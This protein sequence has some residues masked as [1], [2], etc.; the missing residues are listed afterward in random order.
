VLIRINIKVRNQGLTLSIATS[1]F[2]HADEEHV[3]QD[4]WSDSIH[5]MILSCRNILQQHFH[6]ADCFCLLYFRMISDKFIT[7][8]NKLETVSISHSEEEEI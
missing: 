5:K 6:E 1:F 3:Y 8:S 2:Q 7:L 4:V